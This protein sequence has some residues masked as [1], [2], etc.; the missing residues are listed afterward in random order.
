MGAFTSTYEKLS[1]ALINEV[2]IKEDF[3]KLGGGNMY[4]MSDGRTVLQWWK[5]G[6]LSG[7]R[8]GKSFDRR[9]KSFNDKIKF[10]RENKVDS[11]KLFLEK[12]YKLAYD[13]FWATASKLANEYYYFSRIKGSDI[14]KFL[15]IPDSD[16]MRRIFPDQM[17]LVDFT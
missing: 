5:Q 3:T 10:K 8:Q 16:L 12:Y 17:T 13:R 9:L 2:D 4:I 14:S 1:R 6:S 7:V 11:S 15:A